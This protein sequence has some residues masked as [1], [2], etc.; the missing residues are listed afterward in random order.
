MLYHN[1]DKVLGIMGPP[2]L[3]QHLAAVL[4][5][6]HAG[7]ALRHLRQLKLLQEGVP[8]HMPLQQ[9]IHLRGALRT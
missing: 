4:H 5:R 1:G 2:R 9:A 3:P 8:L 6:D 7:G